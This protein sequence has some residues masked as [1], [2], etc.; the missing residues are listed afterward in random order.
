M[1]KLL[2]IVAVLTIIATT[3][4]VSTLRKFK[5]KHTITFL[6]VLGQLS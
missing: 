5:S 3:G 2:K 6:T 1:M 4:M